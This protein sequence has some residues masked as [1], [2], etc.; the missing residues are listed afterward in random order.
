MLDAGRWT[1]GRSLI[2]NSITMIGSHPIDF[3][4]I[5][6]DDPTPLPHHDH[7][8][9]KDHDDCSQDSFHRSYP[10]TPSP[11]CH[12]VTR[13]CLEQVQSTARAF[14]LVGAVEAR[15]ENQTLLYWGFG[16][17]LYLES[18][19]E[20]D[21]GFRVKKPSRYHHRGQRFKAQIHRLP[22]TINTQHS[23]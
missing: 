12:L 18:A 3:S 15:K 8:V 20:T 16:G 6:L 14:V 21:R 13:N 7:N 2:H 11:P 22:S 19:A 17:T 5:C 10:T 1:D 23:H 9:A 4:T